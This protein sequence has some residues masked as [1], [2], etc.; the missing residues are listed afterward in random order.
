MSPCK[1]GT[2]CLCTFTHN[3]TLLLIRSLLSLFCTLRQLEIFLFFVWGGGK[4]WRSN[5]NWKIW[6]WL[7]KNTKLRGEVNSRWFPMDIQMFVQHVCLWSV[8]S[9]KISSW[10]CLYLKNAFFVFYVLTV[11]YYQGYFGSTPLVLITQSEQ[12]K[13][14]VSPR[15]AKFG[16]LCL[17]LGFDL[18]ITCH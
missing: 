6:R 2:D 17:L 13:H 10:I 11:L 3:C 7:Q 1:I 12:R 4:G 5:R 14:K 16:K 9:Q 8:P 15:F 18:I